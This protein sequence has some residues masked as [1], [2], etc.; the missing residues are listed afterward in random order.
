MC[1]PCAYN[2]LRHEAP[3]CAVTGVSIMGC[4]EK[5]QSFQLTFQFVR[6]MCASPVAAV[7]STGCLLISGQL[8]D[9]CM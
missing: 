2:G 6:L 3:P 9:L 1:F 7:K 4:M 5:D 8:T